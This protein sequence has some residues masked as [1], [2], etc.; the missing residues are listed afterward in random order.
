V[1][2]FD[3][4]ISEK[5]EEP[6]PEWLCGESVNCDRRKCEHINDFEYITEKHGWAA[7]YCN[8]KKQVVRVYGEY[9]RL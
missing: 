5:K 3:D 6:E 7:G 1:G 2:I 9:K 4:I 8:T